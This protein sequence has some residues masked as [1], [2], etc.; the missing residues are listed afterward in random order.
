[1][2]PEQR[3]QLAESAAEFLKDTDELWRV[4]QMCEGEDL[5]LHHQFFISKYMAPILMH[6]AEQEMEKRG[7]KY[8]S[9]FNI[10]HWIKFNKNNYNWE[11]HK[12]SEDENEYQAFWMALL[13]AIQGECKH[14]WQTFPPQEDGPL[15]TEVI[16]C[17]LCGRLK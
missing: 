2:T 11:R 4:Q 10:L 16:V 3:K 15:K 12:A 6:L 1:M 17:S 5:P 9:G 13:S 14:D 7:W 8:R